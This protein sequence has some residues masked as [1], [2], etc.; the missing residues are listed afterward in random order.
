MAVNLEKYFNHL[1]KIDTCIV[2]GRVNKVIGTIIEGNGPR[3]GVG[4]VCRIIPRYENGI[5]IEAAEAQVVGFSE[6]SVLLMPLDNVEGIVPGSRIIKVRRF[7]TAAMS[8]FQ[9]LRKTSTIRRKKNDQITRCIMISK[10]G[11]L[12]STFQ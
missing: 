4:S 3:I 1:E 5:E 12:W 10:V 8:S 9:C 7:F 6:E 2:S 11:M